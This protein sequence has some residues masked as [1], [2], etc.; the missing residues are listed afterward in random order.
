MAK[1]HE[2][3]LSEKRV[4]LLKSPLLE[5]IINRLSKQIVE[6]YYCSSNLVIVGLQPR[7]IYLSRVIRELLAS[8]KK[9][10]NIEYAELDVTFYRDDFRLK[11]LAPSP[12]KI[13]PGFS[14]ENKKVILVDDVL[15][16]G[17]TIRSALD[18]IQNYGRPDSVELLVLV[19]R[20]FS[21]QLPIEP[22][23]AG[24]SIDSFDNQRVNIEWAKDWRKSKV[25][26]EYKEK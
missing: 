4:E 10:K 3:K 14:V 24:I 18:A 15:F 9:F 13:E 20:R 12:Q 22:N 6:Q 16:T 25:F 1:S 23:Y 17:R 5:L 21:R 19:N 8:T 2:N 7:G 11:Q 26:L